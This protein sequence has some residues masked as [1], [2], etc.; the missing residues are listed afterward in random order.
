M[1]KMVM[2]MKRRPGMTKDEF[3]DYYETTHAKLGVKYMSKF[4]TKYIRRF[5]HTFPDP[6]TGQL[7]EGDYDVLMEL[8]YPDRATF[9]AAMASIQ[10]SSAAAEI[11]EDEEK[12]FDR[13]KH[14][15][16]FVEEHESQLIK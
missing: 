3:I 8:W 1:F 13:P 4:A 15:I 11:A 7:I 2:M 14:R 10:Q 12:V 9:D 16:Y 5:L 6:V